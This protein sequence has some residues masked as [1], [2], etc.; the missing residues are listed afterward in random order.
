MRTFGISGLP[1]IIKLTL[2]DTNSIIGTLLGTRRRHRAFNTRTIGT[3]SGPTGTGGPSSGP[4]ERVTPQ[5]NSSGVARP[6]RQVSRGLPSPLPPRQLPPITCGPRRPQGSPCSR[7]LPS[8]PLLPPPSRP[9]CRPPPPSTLS[10][11]ML[12]D[13]PTN[14]RARLSDSEQC[15]VMWQR[16]L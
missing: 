13:A 2:S 3:V 7:P 9:L 6:T 15:S 11:A 14:K 1:I 12:D 4:R 16:Q 8:L 5:S 10:L